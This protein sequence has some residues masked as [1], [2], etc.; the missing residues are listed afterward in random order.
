[1]NELKAQDEAA[2][3]AL[4]DAERLTEQLRD[5]LARAKTLGADQAEAALSASRA[6]SVSARGRARE[7]VEYEGDRSASITVYRSQRSASVSTTDL[8][9]GGLNAALE[10]AI[11]M[12]GFTEADP[13]AGLADAALMADEW[14]DLSLYHP[15][16]LDADKALEMA[17]A[18]EAAALDH[19]P[20]VAQTE[21]ATVASQDAL[22]VYGNSHGFVA[23]EHSSRHALSCL[24]I[25]KGDNGMQREVAF[26]QARHY[27]DLD[28]LEAIGQLAASRALARLGARTP[29]TTTAP[30]LFTP[31][32]A[33]SLW[34]HLI[35]AIS[36]GAL[37]RNA[38]FLKDRVDTTIAAANVTLAQRPHRPRGL[39]ST[40]F[41]GDGVATAD[42]TLVEAGVLQGYVLSAYTARRLG[43]A[44]TGNAGGVFNLDVMPGETDFDALVA[45]MGRGLVVTELMGQGVNM[46]NGDYSR[47]AAGFWVENGEIAYPVENA[48]IA[49][50]LLDMFQAIE[51]L[52]DD[53]ELG[54]PLRTPSVLV[55]AMTIA[56]S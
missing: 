17:L 43:L 19:D 1:M 2:E 46:V 49:G 55:G 22:S 26:S 45:G 4:P 10:Q 53:V 20:R 14:P 42:R 18:L 9:E 40:G 35:G 27:E 29:P 15:W 30:V 41:D 24:P 54:S 23:A 21:G 44:S 28:A 48:T 47:G 13:Y 36:G 6:L 32:V 39:S 8:S 52:G 56:G 33:R 31:R 5:M 7:S 37:Y 38:S 51:A 25:V 16:G 50:N 11:T 34:G 3:R 12:A